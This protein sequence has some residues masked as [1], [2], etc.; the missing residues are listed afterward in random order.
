MMYAA[1]APPSGRAILAGR[2]LF[3]LCMVAFGVVHFTAVP[4]TAA[5]V[6]AWLP[7]APRFWAL[8]TGWA[9]LLAGLSLMS[10]ILATLA[11]WLLTALLL[12]FGVFVWMPKILIAR[13]QH[14]PWGGTGVTLACAGAA[15]MV[16]EVLTNHS[17][18]GEPSR[19]GTR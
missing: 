9:M 15:R 19:V 13:S 17:P 7:F 8:A 10:G 3:G 1:L 4:Q 18:A 6:P 11:A 2:V 14:I 16:A 5:M 12:S